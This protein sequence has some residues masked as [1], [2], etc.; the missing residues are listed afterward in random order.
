VGLRCSSA[1]KT[2]WAR[3]R[4]TSCA[5]AGSAAQP[6]SGF[7]R[8]GASTLA[9][10]A[11]GPTAGR[12]CCPATITRGVRED[13]ALVSAPIAFPEPD[14]ACRFTSTGRPVTWA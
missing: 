14:A 8:D 4:G 1:S 6:T 13:T 2:A 12:T 3:A 9:R 11:S 5:H 7:I 10:F